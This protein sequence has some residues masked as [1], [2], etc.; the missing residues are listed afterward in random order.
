[1]QRPT[2]PAAIRPAGSPDAVRME[3]RIP[4]VVY[5]GNRKESAAISVAP[6]DLLRILR[7]AGESTLVHLMIDGKE[8]VVL[9]GE[10]QRD[11]LQGGVLHVDFREVDMNKPVKAAI[12]LHF[13]GEASAVKT[14][15]GTLSVVMH[16]VHV[17]A[18][19][20]ALVHH[21][22]V[23]VDGLKDFDTIIHVSDLALPEGVK[24]LDDADAAVVMVQAPKSEAQL[25]AEDAANA[26]TPAMGEMP[27]VIGKKK[28]EEAAGEG[29]AKK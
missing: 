7:E 8:S 24:V 27:E 3:G 17:E 12:D 1:M 21:I 26:A 22:D 9:V 4:A 10:V 19:P 6:S 14:L 25:A 28:D 11:V 29:D 13:I 2:L 15:G 20:S 18:L 23:A 5:G 16:Q